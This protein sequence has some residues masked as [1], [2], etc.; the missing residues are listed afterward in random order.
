MNIAPMDKHYYIQQVAKIT[1]LSKQVIRKW[2]ERHN[3]IQP[4]RLDNGYRIYSEDEIN[5]LL[6]IKTL[7]AEGHSIKQASLLA[8]SQVQQKNEQLEQMNHY[9]LKLLQSG[10]DCNEDTINLM[11]QQAYN[12]LGLEKLIKLVIIPFLKEVG[13]RWEKGEWSEFQESLSSLAVRDFLVQIRRN[14]QYKSNA[15]LILGA[16]LPYEHHEIPIHLILLQSM[17]KGWRTILIGASPAPGSIE[18]FVKKF[19]PKKVFLSAMTTIP[20]ETDPQL[21][22]NLDEFA[23]NYE[24]INFH[25]GG[26]GAIE[27]TKNIKLKAIHVT[28]SIDEILAH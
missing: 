7:T 21:L 20:F 4:K 17:L 13:R 5:T 14:F 6:T 15:P 22:K 3:I 25:L 1:G 16:C 19:K 27:F 10:T 18:S 11:L 26:D 8:T 24:N 28:N 9:V 23:A 12:Q 2:E